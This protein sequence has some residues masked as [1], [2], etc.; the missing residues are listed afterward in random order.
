[1]PSFL[2]IGEFHLFPILIYYR[3]I[4][5]WIGYLGQNDPPPDGYIY[6][7]IAMK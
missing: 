3:V 4:P 2:G 7:Y 6:L 5:P 1:M